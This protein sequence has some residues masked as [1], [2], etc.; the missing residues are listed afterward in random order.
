M[1][2][3]RLLV[4]VVCLL[5]LQTSAW[6][7]AEAEAPAQTEPEIKISDVVGYDRGLYVKTPDNQFKAHLF[8]YIQGLT[9]VNLNDT[10]ANVATF[11]VRR[12]RLGL[13]G[14]VFTENIKYY[15]LYD[16]SP[17]VLK[18]TQ[19]GKPGRSNS[20]FA[21]EQQSSAAGHADA[22]TSDSGI[23]YAVLTRYRDTLPAETVDYL[24]EHCLPELFVPESEFPEPAKIAGTGAHPR[25]HKVTK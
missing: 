23:D 17:S 4:V 24:K 22:V 3:V 15:F 20:S 7:D 5:G 16:F 18:Y 19:G 21:D 14:H 6:A 10:A 9:Q 25:T 2:M 1:R 8:A 13:K 11:R 12:A